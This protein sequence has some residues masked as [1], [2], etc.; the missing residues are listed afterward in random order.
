MPPGW[1]RRVWSLGVLATLVLTEA[2]VGQTY[3]LS[4]SYR[5][6]LPSPT[7]GQGS[8]FVIDVSAPGGATG[9]TVTA[10]FT[11]AVNFNVYPASSLNCAANSATGDPS[12]TVTCPATGLTSVKINVT[13]TLSG[14]L[15]VVAGIIGNEYDPDMTYNSATASVTVSASS[16]TVTAITPKAGASAGAR[17]VTIT[18]TNFQAGATATIGGT[19]AS[20]VTV[21]SSTQI[22]ALTPSH[23]AGAGSVV[24][25]NSGGG[26]GTLTNGYTFMAATVF[27]EDPLTQFVSTVKAQHILDLRNAVA[28]LWLVAGL[29]SPTWTNTVVTGATVRATDVQEIRPKLNQAL[30]AL[31]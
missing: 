16:P 6:P 23:A 14:T 22:T 7:V 8:D 5:T 20:N 4:L 31:G 2:L 27:S 10:V 12:T 21:V 11:P 17:S 28:N 24:V 30:T 1:C 15:A 25:T 9:V 3:D 26:S 29:G 18:G 19:A 13:P